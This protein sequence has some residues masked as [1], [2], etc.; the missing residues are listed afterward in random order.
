MCT[1]YELTL[2]GHA[3]SVFERNGAVAEEASFACAGHM[4]GSLSHPLAFPAWPT[5]SRLRAL[6]APSHIALGRRMSL[7]DLRWLMRWKAAPDSFLERFTSAQKLAAYS[8]QRLHTITS[9]AALAYEQ[10]QG[11]LLLFK[12]EG[13]QLAYQE[14]FTLLNESGAGAKALTPEQARTLEPALAAD[15]LFHS[16]AYL[17]S[18][19]I[20]NCRQFAHLLKDKLVEAGAELHF[21]TPVTRISHQPGIQI[22]T[23]DHNSHAFDHV[24]ICAGTGAAA[25]MEHGL[26]P[27]ATT[28]VW[29]YS[30]SARIREPLNAPRSAVLDANTQVSISRMG[31]RI[32]VSGGAELGRGD[33]AI[34]EKSTRPLFQA[35]QSHFPGAADFSRNMQIW[36]G[37]SVFSRDALPLI[38]SGSSPG[39]WL[40]VA[41]G[42]NGWTMACGAARVLADLIGKKQPDIDTS[43]LNPG[44]FKS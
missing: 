12:T 35:L 33:G 22:Q 4:S 17:P 41:H 9:Q 16:A 40:N 44:R 1:A 11:Q 14:R 23:Q 32:R 5:G 38:G 36:K 8:L 7:R 21:G 2:D 6:L 19:E 13:E 27:L 34:T 28:K 43:K 25:M 3:V 37:A 29:S 42:H 39:V 20:A 18:D 10:S 24:V 15:L 30:V 31:A 26:G